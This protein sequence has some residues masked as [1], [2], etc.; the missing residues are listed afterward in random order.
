MRQQIQSFNRGQVQ[1]LVGMLTGTAT[2]E[3]SM[4]FPPEVKNS[5]TVCSR[6]PTSGYISKWISIRFITPLFTIAKWW[7]QPKR[8]SINEWIKKIW[9]THTM[10]YYSTF[11][12]EE[13]ATICDIM[14]SPGRHYTKWNK[15]DTEGQ[16]LH[17]STY[18]RNLKIHHQI[19]RE[20]TDGCVNEQDPMRPSQNRPLSMSSACLLSVEKF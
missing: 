3:N 11:L 20:E 16:I 4:V 2:M 14:D 18:M 5:T 17:D 6:N 15:T 8:P 12:R 13:N 9:C 19:H 1:L 10:E 7:K